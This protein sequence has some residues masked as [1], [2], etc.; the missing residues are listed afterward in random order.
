MNAYPKEHHMDQMCQGR[1]RRLCLRALNKV[2]QSAKHRGADVCRCSAPKYI[3]IPTLECSAVWL[4]SSTAGTYFTRIRG[5]RETALKA[6]SLQ[7]IV[8]IQEQQLQA[9]AGQSSDQVDTPLEKQ[10]S[11]WRHEV[12]KL[13]L[14]SKQAQHAHQQHSQAQAEV[15]AKLQQQVMLAEDKATLLDSRLLDRHVDLDL[16]HVRSK[17]AEEQLQQSCRQVEDLQAELQ[18]ERQHVHGLA[19]AVQ[20]ANS[21]H[22]TT[23]ASLAQAEGRIAAFLHRLSY[24]EERLCFALQLHQPLSS[25]S[26]SAST[27]GSSRLTA[28]ENTAGGLA[29]T[30]TSLHGS[31][32][33]AVLHME[34]QRLLADR[35]TLLHNMQVLAHQA[36]V[37]LS[38]AV[39]AVQNKE[40]AGQ[41]QQVASRVAACLGEMEAKHR[42]AL[43]DLGA[44]HAAQLSSA[45]ADHAAQLSAIEADLEQQRAAFDQAIAEAHRQQ[46]EAAD[47]HQAQASH[48]AEQTAAL[49]HTVASLQAALE[50]ARSES[51][52]VVLEYQ[53]Q[54]HLLSKQ[55]QQHQAVLQEREYHM[56]A[57]QQ[58]HCEE[59]QSVQ[60]QHAE[61]ISA[62][63]RE[64]NSSQQEVRKTQQLL[65]QLERQL[66]KFHKS[67][68]DAALASQQ[69]QDLQ[70][71]KE[72][73]TRRSLPGER[74]MY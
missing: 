57:M 14:S 3:Y 25:G 62:M 55:M 63:Q 42:A 61:E 58:Q 24:A 68:K 43:T 15:I 47:E 53:Q 64:L 32:A 13:L 37:D 11:R 21:Q 73:I 10:L 1:G 50:A 30:G 9:A 31:Q 2:H 41:E 59:Q 46:Q 20:H 35:A 22:L 51:Q 65:R 36:K 54:G 18:Q 12:F 69:M 4:A 44:Q 17:R 7:G 28:Q 29:G 5:A 38:K 48:L 8:D 74:G 27:T 19:K 66:A 52:A 70:A 45:K 67:R 56:A 60:Q 39:A 71:E 34:V 72:G 16:A 33:A 49:N 40:R 6:Q 23:A 26:T